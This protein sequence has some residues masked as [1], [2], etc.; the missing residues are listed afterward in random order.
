[1]SP[2]P[3]PIWVRDD[4]DALCRTIDHLCGELAGT[5]QQMIGLHAELA[6]LRRDRHA[7]VQA[8]RAARPKVATVRQITHGPC[9]GCWE[10]VCGPVRSVM[11]D[12]ADAV[13]FA[14]RQARA[15]TLRG[16]QGISEG[17]A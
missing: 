2:L 15:F 1:M 3:A 17:A 14:D 4:R 6:R 16:P 13:A 9:A 12:H 10:T 7:R 5:R 11:H 8:W